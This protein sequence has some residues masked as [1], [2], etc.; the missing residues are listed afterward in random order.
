MRRG[1]TETSTSGVGG[2]SGSFH[3]R[4]IPQRRTHAFRLLP[5]RK[6]VFHGGT[7]SG[8]IMAAPTDSS[9]L[10]AELEE[11]DGDDGLRRL[12]LQVGGGSGVRWG[13]LRSPAGDIG[14]L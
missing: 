10:S 11:D 14:G 3:P 13:F 6:L 12:L 2:P 5:D 8:R 9:L 4:E 7:A 1:T